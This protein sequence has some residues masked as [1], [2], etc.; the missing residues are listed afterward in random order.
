MSSLDNRQQ[1]FQIERRRTGRILVDIPVRLRT[2]SGLRECRITNVSDAGAKLELDN[3]PKVG[4]C[5]W[6]VTGEDELYCTVV[7]S[8]VGACGIEFENV[9]RPDAVT[10]IAG[11]EARTVGP[12]ANRTNIAIGRKRTA[13]VPGSD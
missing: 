2:V 13:L 9:L 8:I 7:W 3:P 6:I 4:V 10:R 11:I 1:A 5:G 12:A